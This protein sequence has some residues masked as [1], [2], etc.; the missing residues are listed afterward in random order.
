VS[1]RTRSAAVLDLDGT[2]YPGA[3]GIDWLHALT[4][5]GVCAA[6]APQRVFAIVDE[7]R[8][9]V[10]DFQTMATRAYAA[11][12]SLLAGVE[13][14]VAEAIARTAWQRQR[15]RLFAFVPELISCLHEHDYEPILISGSPIEMVE[16]V[17]EELD[18]AVARG[19]VFGREA[20]RYTG[21]VDL[22]SGAPG[23]KPK[24]LAA[25]GDE[26]VLDRCFALGNSITDA[27]L[28][29]RVGVPL[30]F[31]PDADLLA[32]AEAHGWRIAT[33]DDVVACTRS[34]LASHPQARNCSC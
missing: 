12:A 8:R 5:A 11:F 32:L 9:G 20:G 15:G 30:A 31:E 29:E 18:I 25:I 16:L 28:F 7:H 17:A 2:L 26:L 14:E 1:W 19:A 22:S 10:I 3:L 23:E 27:R 4:D 13:V 24:I 34:L 21:S 33:R 6:E